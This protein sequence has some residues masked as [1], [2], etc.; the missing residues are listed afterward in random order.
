MKLTSDNYWVIA[1]DATP[2]SVTISI[3]AEDDPEVGFSWQLSKDCA[4]ELIESLMML[5]MDDESFE[6]IKDSD[7]EDPVSIAKLWVRWL[8]NSRS[9]G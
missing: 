6:L 4:H 5:T 3:Q 9:F 7:E 8:E 2:D 1:G